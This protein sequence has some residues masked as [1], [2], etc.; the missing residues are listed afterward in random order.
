LGVL[1]WA[2]WSVTWLFGVRKSD[3]SIRRY[4]ELNNYAFNN[5]WSS[6]Q[7]DYH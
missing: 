1:A 7:D 4:Q 2:T 3:V 5:A 6:T